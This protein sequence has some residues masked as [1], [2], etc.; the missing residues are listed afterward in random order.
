[1]EVMVD[2]SGLSPEIGWTNSDWHRE[3]V[4]SWVCGQVDRWGT[5]Q[6]PLS[7]DSWAKIGKYLGVHLY[8]ALWYLG[9]AQILYWS[10][11]R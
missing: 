2:P 5:G 3:G 4:C 8:N 9:T 11:I 10:L 7:T 1:M 6:N